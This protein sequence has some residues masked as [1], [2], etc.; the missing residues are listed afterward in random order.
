MKRL[1]AIAI[2]VTGMG[3]SGGDD[4]DGSLT[5]SSGSYSLSGFDVSSDGCEIDPESFGT[6]SITVSG[7][8]V[9]VGGVLDLTRTGNDLAGDTF[10]TEPYDSDFDCDVD[11]AIA[12]SGEVTGD[13]EFHL[14][15]SFSF[16]VDSGAECGLLGVTFPCQTEFSYDAAK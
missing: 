5:L 8:V 11:K 2:L 13:D 9:T 7:D 6:Q 14:E 12:A 3:C 15:I 1:L 4:D 16:A 10:L